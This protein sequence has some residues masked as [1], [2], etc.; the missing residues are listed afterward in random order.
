VVAFNTAELGYVVQIE[1]F[2]GTI[3]GEQGSGALRVTMIFRRESDGWKVSHRHA[4]PITTPRA[5][6]S[7]LQ[8]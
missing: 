7:I 2:A 1:R 4:D 5:T 3:D 6:D 8:G